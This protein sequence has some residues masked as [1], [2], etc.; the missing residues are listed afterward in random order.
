[1]R[2]QA[3]I[4]EELVTQVRGL[5]AR[6]REVDPETAEREFNYV[7]QRKFESDPRVLIDIMQS[8]IDPSDGDVAFLLVAGFIRDR[9]PWL[10][11]IL[12]ETHRELKGASFQ[13]A[14]EI[15]RRLGRLIRTILRG[16]FAE[17]AFIR[18][19]Y[20]S[21]LLKEMPHLIDRAMIYWFESRKLAVELRSE[22]EVSG[23]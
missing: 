11:E 8:G 18:N 7:N 21:I 6:V 20:D 2:P 3:E 13:E 22:G 23:S 16:Q 15:G 10:A 1:M 14:N 19:K 12:L 4:L 9:M 17:R 5:S